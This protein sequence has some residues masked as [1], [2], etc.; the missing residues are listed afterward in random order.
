MRQPDW[1]EA[2]AGT[3][4]EL[5]GKLDELSGL[6]PVV[7]ALVGGMIWDF[8]DSLVL[9]TKYADSPIE[10]LMAVALNE[11][12]EQTDLSFHIE[13][14]ALIRT[15]REQYRVDL[16]LEIHQGET[17]LDFAIECDGHEFHEKTREQAR[18]DRARERALQAAGIVVI[19]FTGS[20]IWRN[21]SKC[22]EEVIRI[23]SRQI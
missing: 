16:L 8:I 20:E 3:W 15:G 2:L 18:R 5:P 12:M 21:P 11:R 4:E 22:A 23:I 6:D 19:R 13:P 14:Q 7:K 9:L 10:Q 1:A 17:S